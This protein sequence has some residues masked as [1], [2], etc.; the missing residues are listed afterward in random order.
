MVLCIGL[1]L[2]LNWRRDSKL[3][4]IIW[5]C[6]T[7]REQVILSKDAVNHEPLATKI[8]ELRGSLPLVPLTVSGWFR[9]TIHTHDVCAP[10]V[11]SLYIHSTY[12]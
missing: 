1:V 4:D 12:M 5:K 9:F 7:E 6:V 8:T 3:L 2:F 10:T 11:T